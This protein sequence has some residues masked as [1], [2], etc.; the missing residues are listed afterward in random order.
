[1]KKIFCFFLSLIFSSA[2]C[3]DSK[4]RSYVQELL[5]R[6]FTILKGS[7]AHDTKKAQIQ[8]I[9]RANMN[10][11][12]MAANVLSRSGVD[13]ASKKRFAPVYSQYVLTTYGNALAGYNGQTVKIKAIQNLDPKTY[14]VRT[15]VI[16]QGEGDPFNVD[17][18]VK[19][20]SGNYKVIDIITEG[21]SL[22]STH[23]SEFKSILAN[24]GFD[25]LL[26]ELGARID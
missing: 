14:L 26:K 11:D 16:T 12:I 2:Y 23:K 22:V 8:E 25:G 1:M 10:L 21:V 15:Q 6:A 24:K 5:D 13:D 20:E 7:E 17:C 4:V 9:L 3:D 19:D 18:L